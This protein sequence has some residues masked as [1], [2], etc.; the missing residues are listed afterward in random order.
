MHADSW[1][2]LRMPPPLL[3]ELHPLL[4]THARSFSN[5]TLFDISID[6]NTVFFLRFT[7]S[8]PVRVTRAALAL[9]V[10]CDI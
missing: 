5:Q 4:A 7:T 10:V 2:P 9:R 8:P 1:L 3:S 6:T